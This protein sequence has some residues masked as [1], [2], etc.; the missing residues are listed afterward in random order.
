MPSVDA[1]RQS[2]MPPAIFL[3]DSAPGPLQV[4]TLLEQLRTVSKY[5]WLFYT[6]L[7]VRV[8]TISNYL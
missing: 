6:I 5:L 3:L 1:A 8:R 4:S 7:L 2:Q